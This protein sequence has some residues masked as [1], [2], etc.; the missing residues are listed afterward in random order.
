MSATPAPP[1]VQA[2]DIVLRAGGVT[3]LD[4]V[5]IDVQDGA[6]I[7]LT[8]RSGSGK[9]SLLLVL[10]GLLRP[11]SGTVVHRARTDSRPDVA[12]VFQAP[13]LVPEL[14]AVE[15]VML[16]LRLHGTG[17][18]QAR[19]AAQ[20]VMA[21]MGVPDVA[22]ALPSQLSGGQ[23]Q[24][25]TVARV[26]ALGPRLVLA[27]EPTGALDRPN[28]LMVI[29]ALREEVARSGGSLVVATHDEELADLFSHR[30]VMHEG[31]FLAPVGVRA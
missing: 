27:D 22:D 10:A 31:R 16:P 13:S 7:S 9:T 29:D 21:A 14:T 26:L 30:A 28:A 18:V 23:L 17:V 6:E 1:L 20:R 11:T 3:V 19:D 12:M 5:S 8:G 25:L 4:H 15:N 24:R 2:R